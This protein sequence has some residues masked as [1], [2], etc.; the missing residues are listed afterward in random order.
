MVTG[1]VGSPCASTDNGCGTGCDAGLDGPARGHRSGPGGVVVMTDHGSREGSRGSLEK[2][3]RLLMRVAPVSVDARHFLTGGP[4]RVR[5]GPGGVQLEVSGEGFVANPEVLIVYEIPP[6]DRGRLA[7]FERALL[8]GGPLSLSADV[9]AWRNATDKRLTA[10]CFRRDGIAHMDTIAL[11]RPEPKTAYEAFDRLGGDVWAR[12]TVGAGGQDVFHLTTPEQVDAAVRHYAATGQNWLMSRDAGN[13]TSE[14]RRHQ[15]RVVVLGE[16]VLR[17]CEHVQANPDAPC[18]E[19]QGAISTEVPVEQFPVRYQRL[20]IAATRSVGLPFGGV[21]LAV[22]HG[23]MV[24]EVNVHPTLDV[25]GGLESVAIPFVEA[26]LRT[27]PEPHGGE[28]TANGEPRVGY[29]NRR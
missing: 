23:G 10:Q 29:Q 19:S 1:A 15:F 2:A 26:H 22:E 27:H 20:A 4:G 11:C 18:N 12:P 24:F 17:V 28:Q 3:V 13:F 25:P 14:G 7:T 5:L 21:D 6:A 9:R 16:R 8:L